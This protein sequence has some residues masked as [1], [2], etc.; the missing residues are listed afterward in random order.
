MMAVTNHEIVG[1]VLTLVRDAVR[2]CVERIWLSRFGARW[3]D[4]VNS[5]L[6]HRDRH[7][8][9]DD[10]AFLLK[11]MD[12]TWDHCFRNTLSRTTR[13]YLHLLRDARNRWAHNERFSSEEAFRILDHGV[14]MLRD[15]GADE[16]A[17]QAQD[18][19][20]LVQSRDELLKEAIPEAWH[21]ILDGPDEGLLDLVAQ[22]VHE[23]AGL[24]PTRREVT[25][26]LTPF[27]TPYHQHLPGPQPHES[28]PPV[29]PLHPPSPGS[30]GKPTGIRLW[31][32]RQPV[33]SWI[34][35]LLLVLEALHDCHGA[36]VFERVLGRLVTRD[37]GGLK[38]PVEVGSTGFWINRNIPATEIRRRSY[39]CLENFGHPATDLEIICN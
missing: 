28:K 22:R 23:G 3:R 19:Q 27:L 5:R 7:A 2:P 24:E 9:P 18:L 13:S 17:A 35:V 11:G 33:S 4:Q 12:A 37:R 34:R 14:M 20:L 39:A 21:R 16:S 32:R 31:G 6:P 36:D 38:R 30:D 1:R 15:L 29:S 25:T 10:L 26:I 8:S